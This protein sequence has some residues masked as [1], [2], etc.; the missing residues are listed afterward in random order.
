MGSLLRNNKIIKA[1]KDCMIYW[2]SAQ[3]TSLGVNFDSAES[4]EST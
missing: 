3:Q 1:I 4:V 2:A